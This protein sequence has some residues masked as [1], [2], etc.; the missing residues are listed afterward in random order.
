MGKL[1]RI[2]RHLFRSDRERDDEAYRVNPAF[3]KPP[4]P[5]HP[6][7]RDCEARILEARDAAVQSG[8]VPLF[9]YLAPDMW[10]A[11]EAKIRYVASPEL[12]EASPPMPETPKLFGMLV[13]RGEVLKVD[14]E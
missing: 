13:R 10:D 7:W 2:L 6:R 4:P 11:C 9:L 3:L 1:G 5:E 12:N 8:K 14:E